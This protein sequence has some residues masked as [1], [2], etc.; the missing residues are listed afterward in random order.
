M[1]VLHPQPKCS[2]SPL[3]HQ[4]ARQSKTLALRPVRTDIAFA[5]GPRQSDGRPQLVVESDLSAEMAV[6]D[7]ELEAII[8]LLGDALDNILSGTGRKS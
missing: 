8:H 7:N 1:A 4:G 2:P 3:A 6:G 5:A